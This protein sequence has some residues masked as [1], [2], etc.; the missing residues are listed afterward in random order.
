MI[1]T[2][3]IYTD[4]SCHTQQCVGVWVAIVFI[5]GLKHVTTG[6]ERNTTHNRMELL[7]V[8]K[9]LEFVLDKQ[10]DAT[11]MEV[12]SDSQYVVG[13][14]D[15]KHKFEDL[16]YHTKKGNQIRNVDLVK[17]LLCYVTKL[18]VSLIKIKAH[19][20]KTLETQYNIEADLLCR[21][22]VR[23]VCSTNVINQK[24]TN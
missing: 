9:A 14:L 19:Q 7:A 20:Q 10:G 15:R 6:V 5:D 4:G 23:E 2:I 16:N 13:L 11:H 22:L 3:K 24:T 12:I 1:S 18:K 21:K 8:I 17:Q